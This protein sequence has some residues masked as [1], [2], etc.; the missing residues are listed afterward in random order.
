MHNIAEK[1]SSEGEPTSAS[2]D[3]PL[4]AEWKRS[5]RPGVA[6]LVG[7]SVCFALYSTIAS[8]FVIPLQEKFGWS[9]GEISSAY[10]FGIA[11]ALLAPFL[12][13]MVDRFGPRLIILVSIGVTTGCYAGF[14]LM[15]GSL[16]QYYAIYL[17]LSIFGLFLTGLTFARVIVGEFKQ[18]TGTALAFSRLGLASTSA[19]VPLV[20]YPIMKHYGASGGFAFLAVLQLVIALPLAWLWLPRRRE[21]A[22]ANR[23]GRI[24]GGVGSLLF[25][26]PK[27]AVVALAAVLNYAPVLTLASQLQPLAIAKGLPAQN[28]VLLISVLGMSAGIGA[29][30]SGYLIDRF[31]APAVAFTLNL[32]PAAA[33]L[34]LLDASP[35]PWV[36]Y[37]SV[38]MLGLGQGVE[39]DI[40][41]FLIARYFPLTHYS[42]IYGMVVLAISLGS[43]AGASGIGLLYDTYHSYDVAIAM[44][45]AAF[46]LSALFYLA[47]GRYPSVPCRDLS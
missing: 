20:L 1:H 18:T 2:P 33:C 12:G 25:S 24:W 32:F 26:N 38:A 39:V 9:R 47:M 40:V 35:S 30:L 11:S 6:A 44:C 10:S 36:I 27:I 14:T 22:S 42:T 29:L 15:S 43:A 4:V 16:A 31:W 7:G 13:R 46:F 8:M 34:L 23:V 5:W 41:A 45:S 37:V 3:R 17:V 21:S 19:I 28:A